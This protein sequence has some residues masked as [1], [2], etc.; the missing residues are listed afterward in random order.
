MV[1]TYTLVAELVP[2][3]QFW[4]PEQ[5]GGE[6]SLWQVEQGFFSFF[7]KFDDFSKWKHTKG[8]EEL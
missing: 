6:I 8:T 2:K 1:F 4:V 3:T 7:A 5:Y